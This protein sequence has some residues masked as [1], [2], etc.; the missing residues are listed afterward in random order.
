MRINDQLAELVVRNPGRLY[1]LATVDAYSGEAGGRELTRAVRDLGLR[2]V[3]VQAG[4]N[5]L[6][7]VFR[8]C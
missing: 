5:D 1:G 2:G 4:K 7:L 3:F 8:V 6:L